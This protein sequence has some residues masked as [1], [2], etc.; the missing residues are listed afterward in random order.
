M[1]K[2]R[3]I[4]RLFIFGLFGLQTSI[5]D[6]KGIQRPDS[7]IHGGNLPAIFE[8]SPAFCWTDPDDGTSSWGFSKLHFI[9]RR[10]HFANERCQLTYGYVCG[11]I[12]RNEELPILRD[13]VQR[14]DARYPCLV[15]AGY[16][17]L[18]SNI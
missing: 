13:E 10:Q 12:D 18:V 3:E 16:Q 15:Y 2:G 14:G 17:N 6:Q 11:I 9:F 1:G 7:I 4:W 5:I 8:I